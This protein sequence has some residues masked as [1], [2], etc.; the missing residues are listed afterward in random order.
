MRSGQVF[1]KIKDFMTEND[2][3]EREKDL[4]NARELVDKFE[5]R[6]E[7]EVR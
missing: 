6:L 1:G 2:I 7:A 3:Q 5:E 4:E